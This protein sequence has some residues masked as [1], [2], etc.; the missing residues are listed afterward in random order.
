MEEDS[1]MLMLSVFIVI[2][3]VGRKDRK[4]GN[5]DWIRGPK[6]AQLTQSIGP[7]RA[8][9]SSYVQRATIPGKRVIHT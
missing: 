6:M 7:A 2:T 4:R 1:G 3:C 9:V 8:E 5:E